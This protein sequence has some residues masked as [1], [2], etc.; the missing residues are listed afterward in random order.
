[1]HGFTKNTA[2]TI[3]AIYQSLLHYLKYKTITFHIEMGCNLMPMYIMTKVQG[4]IDKFVFLDEQGLILLKVKQ[5][6]GVI[7]R[8]SQ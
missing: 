3:P 7:V 8:L 5:L 6:D 1:M 2:S 4:V